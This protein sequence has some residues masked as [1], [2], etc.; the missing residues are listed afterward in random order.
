MIR[1]IQI[2]KIPAA[3]NPTVYVNRKGVHHMKPYSKLCGHLFNW[4]W[5]PLRRVIAGLCALDLLLMLSQFPFCRSFA[6][7]LN[8]RAFV[9]TAVGALVVLLLSAQQCFHRLY[10]GSRGI[11]TLCTLPAPGWAFPAAAYTAT[12]VCLL[13]LAAVQILLALLAYP[14]FWMCRSPENWSPVYAFH[15]VLQNPPES[16]SLAIM[17]SALFRYLLPLTPLATAKALLY[18]ELAVLFPFTFMPNGLKILFSH[19]ERIPPNAQCDI[20]GLYLAVALLYWLMEQT[21]RFSDTLKY[22]IG[23]LLCAAAATWDLYN[24]STRPNRV[25]R[26]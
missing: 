21:F 2:L 5:P 11:Y 14:V 13:T 3:E 12:A 18:F 23:C 4:L 19:R 9:F 24:W 22:S 8:N 15:M 26:V 17:R 1:I 6:E 10:T 20:R 25:D 16:L 7:F